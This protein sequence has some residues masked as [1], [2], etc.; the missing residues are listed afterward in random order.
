VNY[1]RKALDALEHTEFSF[2][3]MDGQMPALDGYDATRA[4]RRRE[5]A[6]EVHVPIV[7]LRANGLGGDR[8][9]MIERYAT[10]G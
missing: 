8:R 10:H 2:V 5:A 4:I 3:L 9:A 6:R 1:R 7:A